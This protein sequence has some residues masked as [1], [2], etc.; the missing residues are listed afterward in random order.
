MWYYQQVNNKAVELVEENSEFLNPEQATHQKPIILKIVENDKFDENLFRLAFNIQKNFA[1]YKNDYPADALID[2]INCIKSRK[3]DGLNAQTRGTFQ[4]AICR[5]FQITLQECELSELGIESSS[6]LTVLG[7]RAE[8]FSYIYLRKAL[9]T[10]TQIPNYYREFLHALSYGITPYNFVM[11]SRYKG[12]DQDSLAIS[13]KRF[14]S[15]WRTQIIKGVNPY[16]QDTGLLNDGEHLAIIKLFA[17][18]LVNPPENV[19]L[20]V[21]VKLKYI[22]ANLTNRKSEQD[23][24]IRLHSIVKWLP[25]YEKLIRKT[26]QSSYHTDR[27]VDF[28]NQ[29]IANIQLPKTFSYILNSLMRV[30]SQAKIAEFLSDNTE[31]TK[32]SVEEQLISFIRFF[33]NI[34]SYRELQTRGKTLGNEYLKYNLSNDVRGFILPF[35]HEVHSEFIRNNPFIKNST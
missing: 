2:Y 3:A 31:L 34:L 18:Y 10:N 24:I 13:S 29:D 15:N 9:I 25:E 28:V 4:K 5:I 27:Y 35:I 16:S 26:G 14:I 6:K 12:I 30:T 21:R 19:A 8:L 20:L 22:E 32:S 1:T 17:D 7:K 33:K 23:Y 11:Q